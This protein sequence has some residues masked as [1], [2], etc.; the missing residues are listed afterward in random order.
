M[1]HPLYTSNL[2]NLP[3]LYAETRRTAKLLQSGETAE[4]IIRRSNDDNIFQLEKE[5]RRNELPRAILKRLCGLPESVIKLIADGEDE[6]ARLAAFYALIKSDRLFF[7]FMDSVY[8][9]AMVNNQTEI[10]ESDISAFFLEKRERNAQ[11]AAWKQDNIAA[12]KAT[13]KRILCEA[14]LAFSAEN[15]GAN[16]AILIKKPITSSDLKSAFS[17]LNGGDKYTEAMGLVL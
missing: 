4:A 13:Y 11:I 6:S 7:E 15:S 5:R 2:K 10:A 14:G 1:S 12:L 8:K 9:P 17:Y 16:K 3:F